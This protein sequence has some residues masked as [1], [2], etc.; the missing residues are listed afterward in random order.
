MC[1]SSKYG[2]CTCIIIHIPLLVE[3]HVYSTLAYVKVGGK[4]ATQTNNTHKAMNI[5][6]HVYITRYGSTLYIGIAQGV[7]L[8][9][10]T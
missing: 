5:H 8:F 10:H 9:Y 1:M 4:K 3:I 6:V 7:S 2:T